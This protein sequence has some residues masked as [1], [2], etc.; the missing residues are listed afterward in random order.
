MNE[1]RAKQRNQ[2]APVNNGKSEEETIYKTKTQSRS[3]KK[4]KINKKGDTLSS[5][6]A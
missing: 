6:P 4:K 3:K 5:F 2:K 1:S